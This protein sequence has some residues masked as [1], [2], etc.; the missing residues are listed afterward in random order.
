MLEGLAREMVRTVQSLRKEK[1][2]VIT[3]H[4]N[5]YYNGNEKLDKMINMYKDYIMGETLAENIEKKET[6]NKYM[7]NDIEAYI[8]VEKI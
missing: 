3:D 5:I 6:K 8:N 1:D 4:I 7:L 2:F